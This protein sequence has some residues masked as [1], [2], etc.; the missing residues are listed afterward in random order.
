MAD[1][2]LIFKPDSAYR[3]AARSG[4]WAWLSSE[5]EWKIESLEWFQP[6]AALIESHYDFLQGRPFFPWL[7]DFMSALPVVVGRVTAPDQ[8][9][10]L[11]RYDL[12]ETQIA[13]ARPGS[14]RERYGIYGGL[15]CLHLSDS[16]ESG[17]KEVQRWSEFVQLDQVRANLDGSN[18]KP[19]HTYHLRSL[20][21][22]VASGF[23][24]GTASDVMRRLI[25]DESDLDG[26]Q[27][28]AL[29]RIILEAL[30]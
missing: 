24:T 20:A 7:V 15:N 8:A 13:K 18:G 28:D 1:G 19:D 10:G 22:Q 29:C 30:S 14:L 16:P 23:H 25:A 9:L 3:L 26:T 6:S 5:R 21:T 11:M 17:A 12:G 27:L 4:L 2:L